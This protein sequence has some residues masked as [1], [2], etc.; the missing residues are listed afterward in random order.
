M[1]VVTLAVSVAVVWGIVGVDGEGLTPFTCPSSGCSNETLDSNLADSTSLIQ[2]TSFPV[3]R[4]NNTSGYDP[5]TFSRQLGE[6]RLAQ[7]KSVVEDGEMFYLDEKGEPYVFHATAH[8]WAVCAMQ[9]E[10]VKNVGNGVNGRGFYVAPRPTDYIKKMA[11]RLV[12]DP[13]KDEHLYMVKFKVDKFWAMKGLYGPWVSGTPDDDIQCD[14][15]LPGCDYSAVRWEELA[16]HFELPMAQSEHKDLDDLVG[17]KLL[18]GRPDIACS[19]SRPVLQEDGCVWPSSGF[20]TL[21]EDGGKKLEREDITLTL[22]KPKIGSPTCAMTLK[23]GSKIPPYAL[24]S[25]SARSACC[26]RY[27]EYMDHSQRNSR[28]SC[29]KRP[30]GLCG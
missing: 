22:T 8:L 2:M 30:H 15:K 27:A 13:P 6:A 26:N 11:K 10:G 24:N 21:M 28:K 17:V 25:Y 19:A 18:D 5:S 12:P 23:D 9:K 16:N 3:R 14:Q 4:T 7:V 29:M 1:I 20:P